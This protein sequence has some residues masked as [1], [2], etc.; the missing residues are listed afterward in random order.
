MVDKMDWMAAMSSEV[1]RNYVAG[2][3]VKEA[4]R[5]ASKPTPE[6]IVDSNIDELD[7]AL[8]AMDD[9]ESAVRKNPGLLAQFKRAK[10]FLQNNP[11]AHDKVDPM[12]I[13]GIMMLNLEDGNESETR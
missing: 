11:D 10:A 6:Q 5:E 13:N 4:E 12:F 1:F 3:L 8:T 7:M 2:Q 9:F